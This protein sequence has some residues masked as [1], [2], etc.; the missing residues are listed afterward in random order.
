V[1][2]LA[3]SLLLFFQD[4]GALDLWLKIA[5]TMRTQEQSQQHA[6]RIELARRDEYIRHY[7]E[8]ASR[9]DQC[10]RA[11]YLAGKSDAR[12]CNPEAIHKL[13]DQFFSATQ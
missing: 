2:S 4:Y 10:F 8:L 3:V 12:K 5:E 6:K 9:I 7:N 11:D 13:V 1:I